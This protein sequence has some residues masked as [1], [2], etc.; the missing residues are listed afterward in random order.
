MVGPSG[1]SRTGVTGNPIRVQVFR[2]NKSLASCQDGM[3]FNI[4]RTFYIN[5]ELFMEMDY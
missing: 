3:I 2:Q 4:Y 5:F 1:T